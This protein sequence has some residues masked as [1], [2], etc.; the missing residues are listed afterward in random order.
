MVSTFS[1]HRVFL[2]EHESLVL[3]LGLG[4]FKSVVKKFTRKKRPPETAFN[5]LFL[6][7]EDP[8]ERARKKN[9]LSREDTSRDTHL[10]YVFGF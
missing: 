10:G 9:I 4:P 8:R 7:L 5:F 3:V 2:G 1:V 6:L